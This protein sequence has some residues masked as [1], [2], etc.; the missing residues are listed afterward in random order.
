[1]SIFNKD[2]NYAKYAPPSKNIRI[3]IEDLG[4]DVK[5]S[6]IDAGPGVAA[7]KVNHLFEHYGIN[8]EVEQ[9]S[10]LGLGL[11]LSSEIIKRHN[12]S[13]GLESVVNNGSKFWF[14]LPKE[15]VKNPKYYDQ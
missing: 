5:V 3:V 10:G 8:I 4:T 15:T 12:G 9:S 14:T 1:M 7:D 6:V 11:Y 13:I 2:S